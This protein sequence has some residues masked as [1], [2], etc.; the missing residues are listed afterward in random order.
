MGKAQRRLSANYTQ[1][2][3][4]IVLRQRL[5]PPGLLLPSGRQGAPARP[6]GSQGIPSELGETLPGPAP[7]EGG[8]EAG[9]RRLAR[10]PAVP[11]QTRTAV[12]RPRHRQMRAV[13]DNDDEDKC[14][15]A[16][17]T[18]VCLH[19][20]PG[21]TAKDAETG[22]PRS[23]GWAGNAPEPHPRR[24]P[25]APRSPRGRPIPPQG[26]RSTLGTA[27]RAQHLP[28]S[29]AFAISGLPAR[30]QAV[31]S[32]VRCS[33]AGRS[34]TLLSGA[35]SAFSRGPAPPPCLRR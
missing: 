16:S 5:L 19:R 23:R 27:P 20:S 29:G 14:T 11:R 7:P 26:P 2:H 34:G 28:G 6:G 10:A 21:P 18:R 13:L 1:Q 35:P 25:G 8:E 3:T 22:L 33:P 12:P 31:L 9:Q 30:S 17:F 24:A 15:R 32:L 4:C